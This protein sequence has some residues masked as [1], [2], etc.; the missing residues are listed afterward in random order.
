MTI[1]SDLV[2]LDW[3]RDMSAVNQM[4]ELGRS[5]TQFG[6]AGPQ[7]SN[8]DIPESGQN[9]QDEVFWRTIASYNK[10]PINDYHAY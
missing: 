7:G 4:G 9:G 6:S 10:S 3:N 1:L 2:Q 8:R 5:T